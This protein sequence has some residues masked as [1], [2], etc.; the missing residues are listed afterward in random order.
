[1]IRLLTSGLARTLRPLLTHSVLFKAF[2]YRL[3]WTLPEKCRV[4]NAVRSAMKK[5]ASEHS[6]VRFLNIGAN[7]GLSGDPL[8]EFIVKRKW[9]GVLVEPVDFVYSRLQKAYEG[10]PGVRCAN[11]AIANHTGTVPFWYVSRNNVLPPGYDQ[12]GSFS[13]DHLLKHAS[14]FP[15]IEAF[16]ACRDI[17]SSTVPDLLRK[18]GMKKVELVFI[19]TEGYDFEVIKQ[20]DLK[21]YPPELI[22]YE[23]LHLT[24][25]DKT[26]CRQLLQSAGYSVLSE[27]GDGIAMRSAVPHIEMLRHSAPHH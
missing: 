12:V 8:R 19:D 1:M 18:H 4:Q 10:V 22:I 7:D 9:Q 24:D 11:V 3:L 2:L 26:A 13:R 25:A 27:G 14:T 21:E 6:I 23:E 16:I 17:P 15:G 20:L 5:L